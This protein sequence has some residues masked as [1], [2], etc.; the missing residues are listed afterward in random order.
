[1]CYATHIT[2]IKYILFHSKIVF[3]KIR[4]VLT[5]RI[6]QRFICRSTDNIKNAG[7]HLF[8]WILA[9]ST[10]VY[11]LLGLAKSAEC[12]YL[13]RSI[14]NAARYCLM[15]QLS[16]VSCLHSAPDSA[17]DSKKFA[18]N[19]SPVIRR[20]LRSNSTVILEIFLKFNI[21]AS[22]NCRLDSSNEFL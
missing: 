4:A 19:S 17:A 8:T 18:W 6:R 5:S 16:R 7:S 9:H 3:L 1:M 12:C 21:L 13:Y 11:R 20:I 10:L 15:E 2:F 22:N 14:V